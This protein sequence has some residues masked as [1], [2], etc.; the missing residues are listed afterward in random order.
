MTS[1]FRI[2]DAGSVLRELREQADLS[3]REAADILGWN[4]GVLSKYE[5]NKVGVTLE[6]I[7]QIAGAFKMPPEKVALKCLQARYEAFTLKDSPVGQAMGELL[8]KI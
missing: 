6:I 8:E 3:L 7:D 5:T 2:T 1:K 4:Q